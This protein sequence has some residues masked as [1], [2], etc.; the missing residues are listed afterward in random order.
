MDY[1][2]E[3]LKVFDD[4]CIQQK[5]FDSYII[6]NNKPDSKIILVVSYLCSNSGF[7]NSEYAPIIVL[8]YIKSLYY[9]EISIKDFV[10]SME[11]TKRSTVKSAEK[12]FDRLKKELI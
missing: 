1:I 2:D 4:I 7:S 11:H 6:D 3:L 10:N 5:D 8:S 12:Y 9:R